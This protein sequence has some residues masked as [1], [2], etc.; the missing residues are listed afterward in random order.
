MKIKVLLILTG[1]VNARSD[2]GVNRAF[3][4]RYQNMCWFTGEVL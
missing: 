2:R 3:M 1:R 4:S